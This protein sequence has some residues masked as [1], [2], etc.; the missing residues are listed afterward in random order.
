MDDYAPTAQ[1]KSSVQPEP[2]KTTKAT[3][4]GCEI[5]LKNGDHCGV[6]TIGRC[7]TCGR[8][9]CRTH[10]AWSGQTYYID[11]CAPCCAKTPAEVERAKAEVERA[12]KFEAD[13]KKNVA[14][15]YFHTGS[16][17]TALLTSG[18]QPVDISWVKKQW[19]HYPLSMRHGR[20][21][22]EVIHGRGWILGTFRWNYP[23]VAGYGHGLP[24][25]MRVGKG[26]EVKQDSGDWLTALLDL[27]FDESRGHGSWGLVRVHHV[28]EGY[29]AL[30][31]VP[32]DDQLVSST[33]EV[34]QAV[35]RLTGESS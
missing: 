26:L 9:F 11:Q 14:Y 23:V 31:V 3:G 4:A 24:I 8:A 32:S 7:A 16:A 2:A 6:T 10:Q 30:G 18:V 19:K 21:V 33:E 13:S 25:Y 12:K 20:D 27:P 34:A 15:Q 22:G 28:S 35:K 5:E 17:R 1:M 29:E